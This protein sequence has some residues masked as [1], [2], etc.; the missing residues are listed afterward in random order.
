MPTTKKP[1]K[2]K[3]VEPYQK[4]RAREKRLAG[5]KI[6]ETKQKKKRERRKKVTIGI[7]KAGIFAW[8]TAKA[9]DKKTTKGISNFFKF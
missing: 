8:K 9:A 7:V 6:L 1:A 3:A 2:R 4:R 5:I